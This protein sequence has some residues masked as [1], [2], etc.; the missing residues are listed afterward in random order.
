M[1]TDGYIH[2]KKPAPAP[3]QLG[4][5]VK[6]SNFRPKSIAIRRLDMR[7]AGTKKAA[8]E[9]PVVVD[10]ITVGLDTKQLGH[11]IPL[12]FLGLSL[13]WGAMTFY[14]QSPETWAKMFAVFG[15]HH[16]I[17]IG[18]G[19]QELL[20]EVRVWGKKA[21]S[22]GRHSLGEGELEVSLCMRLLLAVKV[23]MAYVC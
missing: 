7:R 8:T 20:T 23:P 18:G 2:A 13:E 12:D 1:P 15:N 17:R 10:G 14:G 21:A 22:G 9:A 5:K 11:A 3:A 19:S 6:V 16:V 4:G